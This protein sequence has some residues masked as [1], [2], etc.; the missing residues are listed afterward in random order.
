LTAFDLVKSIKLRHIQRGG[1][2]GVVDIT[3]D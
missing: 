2:D 1:S 3:P